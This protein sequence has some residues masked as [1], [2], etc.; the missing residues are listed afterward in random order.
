[1]PSHEQVFSALW[2]WQ[3]LLCRWL[4]GVFV[5]FGAGAVF[6]GGNVRHGQ[7]MTG[8]AGANAGYAAD[9]I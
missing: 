5:P 7:A 8:C 2:H 1:M 6:L 9:L 3:S 4:G